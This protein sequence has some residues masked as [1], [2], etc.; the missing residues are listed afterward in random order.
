[1]YDGRSTYARDRR[2]YIYC[3]SQGPEEASCT[4]PDEQ[5]R[6]QTHY[7]CVP[8]VPADSENLFWERLPR[9]EVTVQVRY[10][11]GAGGWAVSWFGEQKQG[12]QQLSA[13]PY[14][15]ADAALDAIFGAPQ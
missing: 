14:P 12:L 8:T 3:T 5:I 9:G 4:C 1:M 7:G 11:E 2:V 6:Y 15:S 13:K 10:D